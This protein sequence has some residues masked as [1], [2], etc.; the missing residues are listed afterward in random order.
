MTPSEVRCSSG[1]CPGA[2][3]FLSYNNDLA[4]ISL[5][6][7][8]RILL[9]ADDISLVPRLLGTRLDDIMLYKLVSNDQDTI[10]FQADVDL[11]AN[12]PNSI[13]WN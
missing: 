3:A 7:G 5:S 4:F 11:V 2:P 1:L 13:T 8:T 9:F 12:W 10:D 6:R